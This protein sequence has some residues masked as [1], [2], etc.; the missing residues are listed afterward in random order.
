MLFWYAVHVLL[1]LKRISYLNDPMF[2]TTFADRH[3]IK[4]AIAGPGCDVWTRATLTLDIPW[5]CLSYSSTSEATYGLSGTELLSKPDQVAEF[6]SDTDAK[7]QIDQ[8]LLVSPPRLNGTQQWLMEP[9]AEVWQGR[10]ENYFIN[11]PVYVLQNGRRYVG[12]PNC[13]DWQA[14]QELKLLVQYSS[15]G[16]LAP[17]NLISQ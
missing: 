2:C 9:L 1:T 6:L 10:L 13:D 15:P 16:S 8:L 3:P 7:I 12:A 5:Y 11:V 17:E 4:S 14:L